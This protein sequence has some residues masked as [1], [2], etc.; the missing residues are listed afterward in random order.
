MPSI[1]WGRQ[2]PGWVVV[3]AYVE[4]SQYGADRT[5][6]GDEGEAKYAADALAE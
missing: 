5:G 2:S 3:G 6:R 1:S 4:P